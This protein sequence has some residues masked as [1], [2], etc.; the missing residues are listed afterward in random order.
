MFLAGKRL[1]DSPTEA[2]GTGPLEAEHAGQISHSMLMDSSLRIFQQARERTGDQT[3]T[4]PE[5]LRGDSLVNSSAVIL[6]K[7][8]ATNDPGSS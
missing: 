2:V 4:K 7:T 5:P 6:G 3:L 8:D 1:P